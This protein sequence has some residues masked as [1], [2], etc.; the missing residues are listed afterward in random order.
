MTQTQI[1]TVEVQTEMAD[2]AR[3]LLRYG[4]RVLNMLRP[5]DGLP[6]CF[7]S[8]LPL[9]S[10]AP[11]PAGWVAIFAQ[12]VADEW[13][14]DEGEHVDAATV[15]RFWMPLLV[16]ARNANRLT[17]RDYRRAV[18]DVLR[19]ECG[20]RFESPQDELDHFGDILNDLRDGRAMAR[21]LMPSAPDVFRDLEGALAD[22]NTKG[23]IA[24]IVANG[25]DM[26]SGWDAFTGSLM[27]SIRR[28]GGV[29]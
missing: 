29:A 25:G 17:R 3:A 27:R 2:A 8:P 16:I 26:G 23:V 13:L 19:V 15:R 20:H 11:T 6:A 1:T 9:P 4:T 24:W 12:C 21:M 10:D 7:F 5:G 18:A 22:D 14:G 28:A